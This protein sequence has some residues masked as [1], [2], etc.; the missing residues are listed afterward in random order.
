MTWGAKS[1]ALVKVEALM[2]SDLTRGG[3]FRHKD[4]P[5]RICHKKVEIRI[6]H[7]GD[8]YGKL[9]AVDRPRVISR[10]A[11]QSQRKLTCRPR[12]PTNCWRYSAVTARSWNLRT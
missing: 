4:P 10:G 3:T 11:D 7:R 1:P 5:V 2:C 8:R 6:G 12:V 9:G